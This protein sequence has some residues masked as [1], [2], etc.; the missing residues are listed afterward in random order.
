VLG[1]VATLA[2]EL[3]APW[4]STVL[5]GIGVGLPGP[6]EHSTGRPINPPI[7][8][9]WD[10]FDVPA[11]LTAE[12]GAPTLV[13]NDVDVMALG[14]HFARWPDTA[15]LMLVKVATGIGSGIV[16]D[17]ALRRGHRVRRATSGT[18]RCPAAATSRAVAVTPAVWRPPRRARRWPPRCGPGGTTRR[19]AGTSSRSRGAVPW[20]LCN[21]SG[22]PAGTSARCC[23]PPSACST[24][25]VIGG[26]LATA[27]EHLLAAVREVVYRRFLPLAT[28]HLRIVPSRSGGRAGVIGAAVM[29]VERVVS[30]AQVD[31]LVAAAR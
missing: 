17:G 15:H 25:I 1:R 2:R 27:G 11:R 20:K 30:P 10:G 24:V 18:W 22:Q 6:V 3:L 12:L 29:V 9:G 19:R 5:A 13:D 26:A 21:W 4:A 7:M 23:P 16:S 31:E 28:Q 14:E 8:P